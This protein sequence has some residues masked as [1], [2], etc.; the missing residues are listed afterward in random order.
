MVICRFFWSNRFSSAW[1]SFKWIPP[2]CPFPLPNLPNLRWGERGVRLISIE[3]ELQNIRLCI[4][5]LCMNIYNSR[6]FIF[7]GCSKVEGA[8]EWRAGLIFTHRPEHRWNTEGCPT[9]KCLTQESRVDIW[10]TSKVLRLEKR[11]EKCYTSTC[12]TLNKSACNERQSQPG[13]IVLPR[14]VHISPVAVGAEVASQVTCFIIS[15]KQ[16]MSVK[17]MGMALVIEMPIG[18]IVDGDNDGCGRGGDGKVPPVL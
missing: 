1:N 5:T 10:P 3:Y 16:S 9:P 17:V 14:W 15:C 2:L 11:I 6:I 18:C 8:S 12:S 7:W 4:Y 13:E